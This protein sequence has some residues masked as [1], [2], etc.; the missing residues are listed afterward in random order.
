M[1]DGEVRVITKKGKLDIVVANI[2]YLLAQAQLLNCEHDMHSFR[3]Q[4]VQVFIDGK[5]AV[6][7]PEFTDDYIDPDEVEAEA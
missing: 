1:V 5:E 4:D 2:W 6:M 3:A 7:P